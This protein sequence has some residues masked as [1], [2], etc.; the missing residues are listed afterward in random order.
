MEPRIVPGR[1]WD[2]C[3]T[4]QIQRAFAFELSAPTAAEMLSSFH[5]ALG[6]LGD[7]S[8]NQ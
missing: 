5:M 8:A 4:R 7:G 3:A 1:A 2:L 6:I